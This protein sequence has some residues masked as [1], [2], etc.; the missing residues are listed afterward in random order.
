MLLPPGELPPDELPPDELCLISLGGSWFATASGWGRGA[1]S[2]ALLDTVGESSNE[3]TVG[4][5]AGLGLRLSY[6]DGWRPRGALYSSVMIRACGSACM[7]G[8]G[9]LVRRRLEERSS[10]GGTKG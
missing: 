6:G 3:E 8:G 7:G 5:R 2:G 1:R 4:A 9:R 10:T